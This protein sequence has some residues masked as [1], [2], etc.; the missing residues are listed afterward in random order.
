MCA[1]D[2]GIAGNYGC[3]AIDAT[4]PE[5]GFALI[6]LLVVIAILSILV[7]AGVC[8]YLESQRPTIELIKDNWECVESEQRTHIQPM[9]VGKIT[10]MMPMNS[11]VCVQYIR[12]EGAP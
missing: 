9:L 11:T 5:R 2:A 6:E 7:A 3:T 8:L 1:Q 10:V 12:R 4:L